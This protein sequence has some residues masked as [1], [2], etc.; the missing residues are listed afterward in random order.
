LGT[1]V[2]LLLA[3]GAAVG[4]ARNAWRADPLPLDLPGSML[5]TESGARV[6]FHGEA[7]E[8]Y[9]S[10]ETIFVDARDQEAFLA[11]HIDGALSVPLAEV[12]RLAEELELWSGGQ[13]LLIYGAAEN[14][15]RAD[16]LARQLRERVTSELMILAGG[17][18]RWQARGYPVADGP[19]GLLE[20][21]GGLEEE[22]PW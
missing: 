5:L 18:E 1:E 21:G 9:R 3:L 16:E 7:L 13:P 12:S 20:P 14:L 17:F 22:A 2:F 6:V 10:A 4:L 8:R 19:V 11:G 15:L